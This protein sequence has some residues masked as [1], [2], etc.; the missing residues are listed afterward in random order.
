MAPFGDAV[1][2]VARSELRRR[3]RALLGLAVLVA[4][5]G[6]VSL[7]G[8][9]GAR[10]TASAL[11]RFRDAT[12]ARD[13]RVVGPD[14]ETTHAMA[15]EL[16][17][18]PWV[19]T[20]GEFVDFAVNTHGT[21]V[22]S[23]Y[24][25]TDEVFS[26]E[27]DRPIVLEGRMPAADEPD[28]VAADEVTVE[29][30]GVGVGD[31]I[32]VNTYDPED[33][34][35]LVQGDC[36][37]QG[38]PGPA[39]ELE[40]VGVMRDVDAFATTED[41]TPSVTASAAFTEA[42]RD[43]VGAIRSEALV[44]LED[45]GDLDRL[46][47]FMD[48]RP[49]SGTLV[50]PQDD[51][52]AGA[53]D[54]VDVL[55]TSLLVFAIV[56]GLAG[57]FAIFQAVNRQVDAAATA[58][59]FLPALGMTR[60]GWA[61]ASAL[62]TIVAVFLGTM[63]A[64]LG[65]ALAS[66]IFPIGFAERIEPDPGLRLDPLVLVGGGVISAVVIAGWAVLSGRRRCS[67]GYRG[68]TW[69]PTLSWAGLT[70]AAGARLAFGRGRTRAAGPMR[71]AMVGIAIGTIG[72]IGSAFVLTS[73]H[74]LIDEPERW[75]FPWDGVGTSGDPAA[76]A[77]AVD[78]LSDQ[79]GV[80]AVANLSEGFV[81]IGAEEISAY[82]FDPEDGDIQPTVRRGRRPEASDEIAIGEIDLS[83][84]GADIGDRV[85][86]VTTHE[87]GSLDYEVVGV[88]V[89]PTFNDTQ[90]ARGAVL[91]PD[92]LE[93]VNQAIASQVIL[94]EYEDGAA[95]EVEDALLADGIGVLG[96]ITP[97]QLSNLDGATI[98]IQALIGF[99]AALALVGLVQAL[100]LSGRRQAGTIAIWRA[101]GFV[102]R[103][104]RWSVLWQSALVTGVAVVVG[105]PLGLYAGRVAWRL[106]I[107]NLG[108]VDDPTWPIVPA[109]LALP[110]ALLAATL[111]ALLP[112]WL[113]AR[114]EPAAD[115][116][117]E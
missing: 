116:H 89:Q 52:A 77:D 101:L 62:P 74:R 93:P 19:A 13:A 35:C 51:Y 59:P 112:A 15:E 65:A 60:W 5:V 63:V 36:A 3:W 73:L 20:V 21:T 53:G 44:R 61:R 11:D 92:G 114:G 17:D 76:V 41:P 90:P 58:T 18:E 47:A 80:A 49:E 31:T 108:V 34:G 4:F 50:T 16:A 23:V 69:V 40:V 37:F 82:A 10:R 81:Q 46:Q 111:L 117:A 42:Y 45:E 33:F 1:G 32:S 102:P 48:E 71:S 28:E 104:V 113:A 115:L 95:D 7:S 8:F 25:G 26:N 38:I 27:V 75:G 100:A 103:M 88:T 66:G 55:G 9:A 22:L 79:D 91:T 85:S 56:S 67:A 6:A 83:R 107:Q 98:V 72:V 30:L 87:D 24:S 12:D 110:V 99:F 78:T 43:Q 86:I 84:V 96:P 64:P 57:L 105:V 94:L 14:D 109:A 39:I 70:P 97:T 29:A 68:K 2:L 106:T 54:A